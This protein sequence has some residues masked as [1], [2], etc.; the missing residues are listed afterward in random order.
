M[1]CKQNK[2][3]DLLKNILFTFFSD[4]YYFIFL[5]SKQEGRTVNSG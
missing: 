4:H 1:D 5:D 3:F 2:L